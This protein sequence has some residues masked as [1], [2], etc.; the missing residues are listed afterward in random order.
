MGIGNLLAMP[1]SPSE[2]AAYSD[3]FEKLLDPVFLLNDVRFG[4]IDVNRAGE[5]LLGLKK[6]EQIGKDLDQLLGCS[7]DSG[8]ACASRPGGIIRCSSRSAGKSRARSSPSTC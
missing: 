8:E 6:S 1:T 5:R 2:L 7:E 3:L 4:I